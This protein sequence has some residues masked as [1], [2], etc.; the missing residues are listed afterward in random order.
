MSEYQLPERLPE[1]LFLEIAVDG[2]ASRGGPGSQQSVFFPADAQGNPAGVLPGRD[3]RHILQPVGII[4]QVLDDRLQL[5]RDFRSRFA[6]AALSYEG[7]RTADKT[8]IL[9]APLNQGA[10]VLSV[11][12]Y[13]LRHSIRA[14]H[15]SRMPWHIDSA[16]S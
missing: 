2:Q 7:I 8:T 9:V 12:L 16:N 14:V 10:V 1:R 6:V 5:A 4:Q 13:L 11:H 15:L 3:F